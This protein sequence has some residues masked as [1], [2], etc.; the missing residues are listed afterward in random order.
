PS[1][2]R[3]LRNFT[4]PGQP[5]QANGYYSNRIA[6]L[7][8]HISEKST[9]Y[10]VAPGRPGTADSGVFAAGAAG[11][12]PIRGR[13]GSPSPLPAAAAHRHGGE[14][15][16]FGLRPRIELYGLRSLMAHLPAVHHDGDFRLGPPVRG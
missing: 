8:R 6:A 16:D 5:C 4:T 2:A 9:P 15:D 3:F 1:S 7:S 13:P 14:D 11:P 12:A 10:A